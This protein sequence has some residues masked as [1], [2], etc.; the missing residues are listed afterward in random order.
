MIEIRGKDK[1]KDLQKIE[2][3]DGQDNL[4]QETRDLTDDEKIDIVAR[5]ILEEY[6]EA[7]LELAK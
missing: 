1:E 4:E 6:R 5:R 3:Q 7:F 2:D